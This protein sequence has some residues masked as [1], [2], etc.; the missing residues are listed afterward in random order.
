[1]ANDLIFD[2]MN[3]LYNKFWS[4]SIVKVHHSENLQSYSNPNFNLID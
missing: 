4:S 3:T 2:Q 1:M